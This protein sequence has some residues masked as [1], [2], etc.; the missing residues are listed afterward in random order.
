RGRQALTARGTNWASIGS[1]ETE[2][3]CHT[4]RVEG[5]ETSGISAD[6]RIV[7]LGSNTLKIL[8]RCRIDCAC[9]RIIDSEIQTDPIPNLERVTTEQTEPGTLLLEIQPILK[10]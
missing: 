10:A 1:V 3:G 5:R 8:L 9:L 6:E 2:T 7:L 4:V